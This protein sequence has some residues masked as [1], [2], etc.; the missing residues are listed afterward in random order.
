MRITKKIKGGNP[1]LK[2]EKIRLLR[3][4]LHLIMIRIMNGTNPDSLIPQD[5]N[6][7][8]INNSPDLSLGINTRGNITY[9]SLD[10]PAL[11]SGIPPTYRN[12]IRRIMFR[13]AQLNAIPASTVRHVAESMLATP[14]SPVTL[15]AAP[16]SLVPHNNTS[17]LPSRTIP[18]TLVS[19]VSHASSAT[20]EGPF[21]AELTG[22]PLRRSTRRAQPPP[23]TRQSLRPPV[24]ISFTDSDD[25]SYNSDDEL[26]DGGHE[27]RAQLFPEVPDIDPST[28][29]NS[30]W[31]LKVDTPNPMYT[32]IKNFGE[33]IALPIVTS[34]RSILSTFPGFGATPE[35]TAMHDRRI[36][37]IVNNIPLQNPDILKELV[38][39]MFNEAIILPNYNLSNKANEFLEKLFHCEPI[40]DEFKEK[41]VNIIV[42]A[43]QIL[44]DGF[45]YDDP[46]F[47]VHTLRLEGI[48][49]EYLLY[50]ANEVRVEPCETTHGGYKRKRKTIKKKGRNK[51]GSAPKKH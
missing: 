50:K 26:Y 30:F 21:C 15:S 28:H 29:V 3:Y 6:S 36:R 32:A 19:P 33:Q 46:L 10:T 16:V 49:W 27:A 23:L 14:D 2:P 44:V 43:K 12:I 40:T 18:A 1:D 7:R 20:C 24:D 31:W 17:S 9:D 4:W 42:K 39:T 34:N 13:L 37:S 51:H 22:Q 25:P 38:K 11:G 5:L 45:V 8:F 48:G 47:N 41:F 35:Y